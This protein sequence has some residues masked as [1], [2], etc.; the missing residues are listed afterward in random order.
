MAEAWNEGR[1]VALKHWG[2]HLYSLLMEAQIAPFEAGQFVKIG[3]PIDGEI[4]GRPYSLVNA[5]GEQPLE[6]YFILIEG[7]PLSQRLIKLN[8]G[9][10]IYIAPRTAGFLVLS[11]VPQAKHLWLLATGTGVGPFLSILKTATPWERFEK[12]VLVQA[13]RSRAELTYR[14]SVAAIAAAHHEQFVFV[15]FVSREDT[16]FAI[17]ARI[18]QAIDDGRLEARAGLSLSPEHSQFMLCGNP[19]MVRDSTDTLIARGF[20]K[21]RRRNPGHITVEAYW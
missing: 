20:K 14:E 2:G 6:F 7:G 15:P 9:E 17:R 1:V 5:P 10:R 16:T 11:E 19:A 18:P 12:I 3:L 4:V 13:V 21:H 8:P